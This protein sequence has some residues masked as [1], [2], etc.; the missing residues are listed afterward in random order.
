[1]WD[2]PAEGELNPGEGRSWISEPTCEGALRRT[3]KGPRAL[4]VGRAPGQVGAQA[5]KPER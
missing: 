3:V 1:M 5:E 2:S 4:P